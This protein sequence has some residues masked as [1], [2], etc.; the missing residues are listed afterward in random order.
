MSNLIKS[1]SVNLPKEVSLQSRSIYEA[2]SS[3]SIRNITDMNIVVNSIHQ[4]VNRCIADKGVNME[5]ADMQYL[6]K[7]ITDDIIKDFSTLSLEDI[8]MCFKIGVRGVLG[9]YFG[10]N[11]VTLY[12]WLKKYKD[13][14]LPQ[15][16]NEVSRYLPPAK[17]E[18]PKIDFK[19]L[20]FEKIEKICETIDI[21]QKDNVYELN[22]YGNIHYNFLEKHG[23][24]EFT[25][26]EK[27]FHKD[28]ARSMILSK[29]KSKNLELVSK[30]KAIQMVNI[31][32][33]IE[34]IE[35][36]DKDIEITT[37]INYLKLLLKSFVVNFSKNGNLDKLRNDLIQK[38]ELEYG[39]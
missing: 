24:I 30:G 16:H 23:F 25:E 28:N 8:Q 1:K 14:M 3:I 17:I 36:G 12:Q 11:V 26:D 15:T 4:S 5:L 22:D 13:E 32:D 21:Y 20:D 34:K 33:L 9:D 31:N 27:K 19:K 7:S 35:Y 37:E 10:I 39:K 18:E 6:K 38:V 29:A 2:H